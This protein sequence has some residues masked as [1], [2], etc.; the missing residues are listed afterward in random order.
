LFSEAAERL[1]YVVVGSNN[2]RNGP[3]EPATEAMGTFCANRLFSGW[4]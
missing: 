1:G 4:R 3:W 2:S